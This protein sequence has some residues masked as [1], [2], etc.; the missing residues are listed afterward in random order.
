M[1]PAIV[2]SALSALL[3]WI[4]LGPVVI[5]VDTNRRLY[6]LKLPGVFLARAEPYRG[7]FHVRGRILLFPY[8]F[9]PFRK[10]SSKNTSKNRNRR[11]GSGKRRMTPGRGIALLR[12]LFQAIRIRELV[13]D[14]DTE[15]PMLNAWLIPAFSAVNSDRISLTAN[16]EGNASL[17]MDVRTRVGALAWVMIKNRTKSMLNL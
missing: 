15:D 16:F 9:D 13:L 11:K 3:L 1:I 14:V 4:L 7:L 5:R 12:G 10:R 6:M 8:S 2:I 17:A